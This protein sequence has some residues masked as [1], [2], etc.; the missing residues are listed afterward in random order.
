MI[1]GICVGYSTILGYMF[2]GK[3]KCFSL[4]DFVG[5]DLDLDADPEEFKGF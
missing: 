5:K 3:Y 4:D 2:G 1:Y